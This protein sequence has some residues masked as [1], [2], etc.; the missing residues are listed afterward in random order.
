MVL[1]GAILLVEESVYQHRHTP[2]IGSCKNL[3]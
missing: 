1:T 2:F 3:F